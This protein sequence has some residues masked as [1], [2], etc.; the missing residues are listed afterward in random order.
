MHRRTFLQQ[1]AATA[2]SGVLGFSASLRGAAPN[3]FRDI[4]TE[5]QLFVDDWMIQEMSGLKRTLHQPAKKGLIK[6]AD[7]SD[8][9]RGDV[10]ISMMDSNIVTRNG[11]GRFHMTYRYMWT[12][13]GVRD[14]NPNIGDDRAH[15]YRHSTA[16]ATSLDGIHWQ[17]PKLRLV[18]GPTDFRKQPEFPFE[19]PT[20]M[21]KENNLGC[22][23]LFARD[24]AAH[25]N[26]DEPGQ[27]FLVRAGVHKGTHPFALTV[28]EPLSFA[29]D[30]PDLVHDADWR[31]KLVPIGGAQLP[32]R[33]S[34]VGYD[35]QAKLWFAVGQ[36]LFGAWRKRNGRDIARCTSP[37]LVSWDRPSLVLPVPADESKDTTDWVEYMDLMAYRVGGPRSGAWLGQLLIFHGDRSHPQYL[38]PGTDNVWRKGTTELRLVLSRDAGKTWQRVGDKQPWL[39]CNPDPH[40][41]DRLVFPGAPLTVNDELW[42][43]YPAWDGDHLVYN[44]D[45]SLFEPGFMRTGRTALATL[46]RDGYVSLDAG[47]NEGTLLTRPFVLPAGEL[48]VNAATNDGSLRVA[49]CGENGVPVKGFDESS[50][51]RADKAAIQVSWQD[52]LERLRG[53]AVRL[54]FTL[55]RGKLYSFWFGKR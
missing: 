50:E 39:P 17:K 10:Y 18:D 28:W 30:W 31:K 12:D 34:L 20:G 44:R 38:M 33:G 36:D 46:R 35:G 40:G 6:E 8:W 7:G 21:S 42:F 3:D 48:H 15:W 13:P 23:L 22:P 27:R 14:L 19:V 55:E 45:G 32:P 9:Q 11:Q 51:I 52:K 2:A 53:Q 43:Y 24:L 37:D 54:R 16:Y 41:F 4:G 29:A 49:V 26:R 47:E 5:P 25:G 1:T